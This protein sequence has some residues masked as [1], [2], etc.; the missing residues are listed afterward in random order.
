MAHTV[1]RAF[2]AVLELLVAELE[3]HG[4]AIVQV[5]ILHCAIRWSVNQD[6]PCSLLE[7]FHLSL[8]EI[9]DVIV[10]SL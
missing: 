6:L 4:L 9:E 2:D 3:L 1:G 10:F 7:E 8:A 5:L